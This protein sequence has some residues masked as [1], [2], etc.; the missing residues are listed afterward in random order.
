MIQ[1]KTLKGKLEDEAGESSVFKNGKVSMAEL[2]EAINSNEI[3]QFLVKDT[4]TNY[5]KEGKSQNQSVQSGQVK[6]KPAS[7]PS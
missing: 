7:R 6:P 1:L 2:R 4:L 3:R 5:V